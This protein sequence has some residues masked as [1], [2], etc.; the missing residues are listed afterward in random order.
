MKRR[1]K[2]P[3]VYSLYGLGAAFI[4]VGLIMING[5]EKKGASMKDYNY[6]YNILSKL[7]LPTVSQSVTLARPYTDPTIS[8]VKDYYDYKAESDRQENALIYYE[9][10]YIQSTGVS[11]SN[12][13]TFN[14]VAVLEGTVKS[15]VQS[16]LLGS[17][18]TIEHD[19]ATSIYQSLSEISVAEGEVVEQGTIIGKSGTSNISSEL[20]NHLYFELIVDGVSVNPEEY[21]DKEL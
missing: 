2:K 15:V 10:T 12:G 7:T 6:A 8:I 3:V 13:D 5:A 16:D 19:G 18:I 9:D 17:T 14:V 1:L 21:Y 20:N 4:L 11:Y